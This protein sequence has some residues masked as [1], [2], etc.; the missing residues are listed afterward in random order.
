MSKAVTERIL[1]DRYEV[2]ASLGA[3]SAATVYQ[4]RDR[5]SGALRAAKVLTPE[6]AAKPN[7]LARFEDEFRILRTLHHPHLPEVYDFGWTDDGGRFLVMELVDGV[8]LDEY[9]RANPRDIWVIL[10][11]LCEALS[12]VHD[13][14]LLHQDIKPANILV[15]RTTAFGPDL[16]LV[17][18]IDF[19]LIY[20]RDAGAKVELV[21]TPDYLA[22]EVVRGDRSLTRAVDYYSLGAT[23]YELLVGRTPFA[24]TGD[25]LRAHLERTPVIENEEL[26]WAELY[27]HVRA[28]LTKDWRA[29][30]E[31][32]EEFRRAVVSRLTGGIEELDRAYRLA[33]DDSQPMIGKE[34]VDAWL[35]DV[36]R[37]LPANASQVH[38]L[39]ICGRRGKARDRVVDAVCAEC[40]I[41]RL[42]VVRFGREASADLFGP[43]DQRSRQVERFNKAIA[44][45]HES[46]PVAV[47]L[48]IDGIERLSDE[49]TSFI[50]Y[51]A[52]QRALTIEER[53]PFLFVIARA[54]VTTSH[55][56]DP[57]LPTE[58]KTVQLPLGPT[59]P[60]A[61]DDDDLRAQVAATVSY[62][63]LQG[64][65]SDARRRLLAYVASHP[66]PVPVEWA[67]EFVGV[68]A[69]ELAKDVDE[70]A[71]RHLL[72]RVAVGGADALQASVDARV[73]VS[74]GLVR[75]NPRRVSPRSSGARL[76]KALE[77][78]GATRSS[79]F[80]AIA[81]SPLRHR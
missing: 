57:Y 42:N 78:P 38:A 75:R 70:L 62:A 73:V 48:V 20:K 8:P 51:F 43:S 5:H 34:D 53:T 32:F 35:A 31:A 45:L 24:G 46:N 21:G 16:P 66:T 26:E 1:A 22:P 2:L 74:G 39:E 14:K 76:A 15:K 23:L 6:N 49:E 60:D 63:M 17:K 18:L 80:E 29:R 67:S 77:S 36:D 50:R 44:R 7:V 59:P 58:R 25:V 33:R 47:L 9:F 37:A 12:F 41:R 40:A 72:Q 68:S 4:V 54:R 28:L 64:E 56:L 69:D 71:V 55:P 3:G 30:L 19:G 11:E 61:L 52:T 81:E 65:R 27:P 13:H 79:L 10:Y